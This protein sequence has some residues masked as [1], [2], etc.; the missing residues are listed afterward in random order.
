MQAKVVGQIV[1]GQQA[2]TAG[3]W[4]MAIQ[5]KPTLKGAYIE[6]RPADKNT[7]EYM[8]EKECDIE[9]KYLWSDSRDIPINP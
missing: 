8:F 2:A 6:L 1:A 5:S 4:Q 3:G 9:E 7:I